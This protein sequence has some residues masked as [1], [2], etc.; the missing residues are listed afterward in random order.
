[1]R[2]L[3]FK[4]SCSILFA[5]LFFITLCGCKKNQPVVEVRANTQITEWLYGVEYEDFDFNFMVDY[6]EEMF[7][8]IEV[9][10]SE[11]RKGNYVGR[12]LDWYITSE[13]TNII[14]VDAKNREKAKGLGCVDDA[15]YASIGTTGVTG[16][17]TK[18]FAQSGMY[19]DLY[20]II[21][22]FQSDGINENGLYIGINVAP[23]GEMSLDPA[24]WK[25]FQW[26]VGAAYTN[27]GSQYTYCVAMLVRVVL[28]H[29]ASVDDAISIIKEVNWFEPMNFPIDGATQSFHWM[30]ADANKTC[31]VEFIDNQPQFMVTEQISDASLFNIMTNFSNY[32][33][34]KT[35]EI[36]NFASGYER[37]SDAVSVYGS[38]SASFD[39]MK[40]IMQNLWYS[41]CYT[42]QQNT[43][44]FRYSDII[45]DDMSFREFSKHPEWKTENKEMIDYI[46]DGQNMFKTRTSWY[47]TECPLWFST[48][49]AVYDIADKQFQIVQHEHLDNTEP[50][51]TFDLNASF[52]KP[53]SLAK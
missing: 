25:P 47:T 39:G 51:R 3:D 20:Q 22:V 5:M 18:E 8:P 23:T 46:N 43:E 41:K 44:G 19:S 11:V 21:P 32:V 10:C 31:I 35:G 16:V 6:I 49:T 26:G 45:P 15:R 29:A 4:H 12:N 24:K 36:Q 28:D 30:V 34:Y 40:D 7:S 1:M 42:Q 9:G 27:P 52:A 53:L 38:V 33:Y 2:I 14:K 13:A 17:Y 48:H 37:Y 50:W